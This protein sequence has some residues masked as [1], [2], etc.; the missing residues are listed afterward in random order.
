MLTTV[1]AGEAQVLADLLPPAGQQDEDRLAIGADRFT[2]D[3]HQY[4]W[5][6]PGPAP[7]AI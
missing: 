4:G 2:V 3:A 1:S 7:V 5:L 6:T